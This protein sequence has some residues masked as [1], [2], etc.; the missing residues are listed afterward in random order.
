MSTEEQTEAA[1]LI[2]EQNESEQKDSFD[3]YEQAEKAWKHACL[4]ELDNLPLFSAAFEANRDILMSKGSHFLCTVCEFSDTKCI[5]YV[6]ENGGQPFLN[7]RCHENEFA[8]N[9]LCDQYTKKSTQKEAHKQSM[10]LLVEKGG[11][12]STKVLRALL[13]DHE[14]DLLDF[15]LDHIDSAEQF[16]KYA[17]NAAADR[18][19]PNMAHLF[20]GR[21]NF[22]D[23]FGDMLSSKAMRFNTLMK[24]ADDKDVMQKLVDKGAKYSAFCLEGHFNRYLETQT[25]CEFILSQHGVDINEQD[26]EGNTALHKAVGGMFV[27]ERTIRFARYLLDHGAD[28]S[29]KNQSGLTA[30]DVVSRRHC[31][32]GMKIGDGAN[33][34]EVL[35]I[36]LNRRMACCGMC[37]CGCW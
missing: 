8:F 6:L 12:P 19:A 24:H 11:E 30:K 27:D 32:G 16:D 21:F 15:M 35:L 26:E 37:Q 4:Y 2:T 7:Q 33:P 10:K 34:D 28:P 5:R 14:H 20:D 25:M 36:E 1:P 22:N 23:M 18:G 13:L 9:K 17:I 29:V 31:R 3:L